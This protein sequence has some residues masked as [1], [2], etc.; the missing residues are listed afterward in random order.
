MQCA[1]LLLT[2][3]ELLMQYYITCIKT[4]Y[5]RNIVIN[6]VAMMDLEATVSSYYIFINVD[7]YKY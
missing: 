3:K 4:K 5:F 7:I 2:T 6:N 1:A